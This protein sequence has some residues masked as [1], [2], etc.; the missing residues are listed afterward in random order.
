[1]SKGKKPEHA[2]SVRGRLL[3]I[4]SE[5]GEDPNLI[6]SR[7]ATE[8][9]LYRLSVSEHANDFILKGA[10]LFMVWTGQPYRPTVDIDLLGHGDS[11]GE[12]LINIFRS[13]CTLEVGPDGLEF[14]PDTVKCEPIREDQEY[15]GQRLKL[16]AFLGKA[17]IRIQVDIG[18]GD[19]VIPRARKIYYPTLLDF[20]A[21][22]VRAC[23]P[24][25]VVAEK[26]QAM[27]MLGIAN[28][29]MKDFYDLF[30]MARDFD[31]SGPTLT[32]AIKATFKRRKTE[33]PA[34]TPLPL[35]KKFSEH[36]AKVTQWN[37]F[38]RKSGLEHGTPDLSRVLYRLRKF[39]LPPLRGAAGQGPVPKQW[40]KGGPWTFP[41]SGAIKT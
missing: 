2:A 34:E 12:R 31:F 11:S 40:K 17:R 27:V 41:K 9:F 15:Q 1:M 19:V 37:A 5:T 29:R 22:R 33:I 6:W 13:L 32:R 8:R 39:L 7:Y 16:S 38:L 35:T 26:L 3:N 14:D 4:I 20:P 21:P 36:D 30:V 28:S 23:P 10:L 18:F 24:E 25:T